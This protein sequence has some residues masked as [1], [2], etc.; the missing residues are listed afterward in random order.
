[1]MMHLD[2]QIH[3]NQTAFD[4]QHT[5]AFQRKYRNH[6]F[7]R[8]LP[9]RS[10]T[11]F[12]WLYARIQANPRP[13]ILDS[14][15]GKGM[16]SRFL[17]ARYPN[18]WVVAVDQSA[19]RLQAFTGPRASNLLVVRDNC[20]DFWQQ[21]ASSD[22]EI[23][24]HMLLYP[25]PYPKRQHEKRRW[26]AH[27]LFS[28]ALHLSPLTILRSNWLDYLEQTAIVANQLGFHPSIQRHHTQPGDAITHFEQKYCEHQVPV[29]ELRIVGLY[30][31]D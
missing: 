8:P 12:S 9:Q 5:K 18:H 3:S 10:V 26:Y 17:A 14:G 19:Q 4:R 16:S 30:K 28:Q 21:L 23:A 22:L 2:Y 24:M 6:A 13:I 27:P 29:Y 31:P 7:Q 15:C 20:C 1:M 25:N 11:A